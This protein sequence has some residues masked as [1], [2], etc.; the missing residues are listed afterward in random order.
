MSRRGPS[1]QLSV[2]EALP[3][4]DVGGRLRGCVPGDGP[5]AYATSTLLGVRAPCFLRVG[6]VVSAGPLI[7]GLV[8][9]SGG[10]PWIDPAALR[11]GGGT[12]QSLCIRRFLIGSG[13]GSGSTLS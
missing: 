12:R 2:E 10:L 13:M 7:L 9:D 3:C 6:V 4:A 11:P 1:G 5:L 8:R